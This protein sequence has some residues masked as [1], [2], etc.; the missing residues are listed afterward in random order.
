MNISEINTKGKIREMRWVGDGSSSR[1][2]LQWVDKLIKFYIDPVPTLV[3][4]TAH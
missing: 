4:R 1:E 2:N 3:A